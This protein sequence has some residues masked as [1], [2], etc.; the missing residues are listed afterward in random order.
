MT[1]PDKLHL[2]PLDKAEFVPGSVADLKGKVRPGYIG[3][4]AEGCEAEG[5]IMLHVPGD[6][7]AELC[8]DH[9][10]ELAPALRDFAQGCGC[11]VCQRTLALLGQTGN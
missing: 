6:Q 1:D 3:C 11:V 7:F 4:F 5:R 8:A 10:R 2:R 9:A